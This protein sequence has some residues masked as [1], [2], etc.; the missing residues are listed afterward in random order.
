MFLRTY[1]QRAALVLGAAMSGGGAWAWHS[2]RTGDI[3]G[4]LAVGVGSSI[5]AAAI[6]AFLSPVNE[7]GFRKF[8][9]LGIDDVWS[10]R[11]GINDR[12]WVDWV[13]RATNRCVLLG[14]AHGNW[15]TD[16]RFVPT[17]KDR[18]EEGV[19]FQILFLNPNTTFAEDR[20][21][22]DKGK[23]TTTDRIRESIQFM[24]E[25]RQKLDPGVR[26]RL[27]LYVYKG[28]PSCG[29]T[30]IV[31]K[32]EFMVVTH[33]LARVPNPDSPAFTVR[34]PEGGTERCLYDI[35][36]ENLDKIIKEASIRLDDGNVEELLP[37]KTQG[38][39][40]TT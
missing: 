1:S 15:C 28:T 19:E 3:G 18:L 35:Y 33:Y 31:G 27:Q 40:S 25:I 26:P 39:K 34:R 13:N 17:L 20:A 30:W 14:I 29:L 7:A 9:S 37:R 8:I 38:D 36:A 24:W 32:D 10:S 21:Q 6:V 23:R 2:H 11:R 5:L 12:D 22:E 16:K 4:S